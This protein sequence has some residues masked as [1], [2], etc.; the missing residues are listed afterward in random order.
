MP[1]NNGWSS[2]AAFIKC[3]HKFGSPNFC[4]GS[5]LVSS[6]APINIKYNKWNS[7]TQSGNG[8]TASKLEQYSFT[9]VH[10]LGKRI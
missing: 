4:S 7:K 10:R 5:K 8:R 1:Y 2:T 9:S 6:Y 3:H